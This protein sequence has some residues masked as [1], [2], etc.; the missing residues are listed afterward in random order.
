MFTGIV[1]GMGRLA[2]RERRGGDQRL[3]IDTG[4]V[5][6]QTALAEGASI[7]V[8]GVCLT[9]V[10]RT[11]GGFAADASA[12]TLARTTL[13]ALAEGAPVNL[14][15]ALAVGDALGGHLVSG[16]VDGIGEL[17][18]RAQNARAWRLRFRAPGELAHLIAA[19]GSIAVDG[20]S[21]TVNAVAG[22]TFDV[23]IVPATFERT[24]IG[25]YT[26]G[27]RVNL[28]VDMIARYLA[29]LLEKGKSDEPG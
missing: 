14:E 27:V 4:S 29:R 6:G 11:P 3:V 28:E 2:A 5:L 1:R 7:A 13:G 20:V 26:P 19:K 15:P 12:E 24:A 23:A 25:T 18:S 10:A 21:L 22:A 16:H 8:N 17:E 9:V